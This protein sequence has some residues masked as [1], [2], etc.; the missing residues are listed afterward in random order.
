MLFSPTQH[1]L[2][3]GSRNYLG[4]PKQP[5]VLVYVFKE[6]QYEMQ[7]FQGTERIL[8]PTFPMLNLTMNEILQS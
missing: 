2:A 1:Y 8:S 4:N 5:S 3:L 6:Q 7:R